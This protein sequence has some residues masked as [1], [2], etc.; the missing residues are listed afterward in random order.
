[1]HIALL[2]NVE[3]YSQRRKLTAT[4]CFKLRKIKKTKRIPHP[5]KQPVIDLIQL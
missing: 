3:R 1:M 2:E 5:T 4:D